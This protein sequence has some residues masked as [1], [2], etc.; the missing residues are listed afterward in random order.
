[1]GRSVSEP[2]TG[3]AKESHIAAVATL[4]PPASVGQRQ[5]ADK[6]EKELQHLREQR[7]CKICM[8]REIGVVFLPCGHFV[9]CVHC[10]PALKDCPVCR[11]A[12]H[13]T[14]KTYLT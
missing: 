9:S 6:L 13:A 5:E 12:I 4:A 2:V 14:V 7:T 8:D 10:A 3:Q 1:M 11:H